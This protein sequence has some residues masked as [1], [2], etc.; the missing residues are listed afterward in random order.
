MCMRI[1]L[2]ILVLA[3]HA[4]AAPAIGWSQS[5]ELPVKTQV[6]CE[7]LANRS[8]GAKT[9]QIDSVPSSTDLISDKSDKPCDLWRGTV[10]PPGAATV[11]SDTASDK[12]V[13]WPFG[14]PIDGAFTVGS[15]FQYWYWVI[16]MPIK[17]N[18]V[19]EMSE[20][21]RIKNIDNEDGNV[22]RVD[23]VEG[24]DFTKVTI[25]GTHAGVSKVTV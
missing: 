15:G 6:T 17:S 2:V 14:R 3:L 23:F 10:A 12:V 22:V 5:A 19:V 20:L 16:T 11:G 13:P 24:S 7:D 25:R 18:H 9:L 8:G 21:Q 1:S 4:V